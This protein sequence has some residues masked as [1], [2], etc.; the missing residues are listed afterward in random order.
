MSRKVHYLSRRANWQHDGLKKAS[1]SERDVFAL[2]DEIID[3]KYYVVDIKPR[4]AKDIYM[5]V[6]RTR[7]ISTTEHIFCGN[8]GLSQNFP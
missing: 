1:K 6:Y 5:E 3:P 7:A 8:A 2:F 4:D